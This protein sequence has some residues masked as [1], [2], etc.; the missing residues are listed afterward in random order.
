MQLTH[1][2]IR[3]TIERLLNGENYRPE[4]LSLIDAEF[5][6]FVIA[7]FR[8]IVEAKLRQQAVTADWYRHEFLEDS[9]MDTEAIAIHAGLNMKTIRNVYGTGSRRVVLEASQEHF[10][11]LYALINDLTQQNEIDVQ[12]TLKFN[13]VSVELTLSESL[14]V[15]NTLAVKR[16]QLRGSLWSAVG[17]QV[18]KPLMVALC[19]LFQVP[20]SHYAF[21]TSTRKRREVDF[22]LI[23]STGQ[24]YLCEVKLMGK[25]NPESADATFARGTHVFIADTL[26]DSSKEQLA[27]AGVFWIELKAVN[28]WQRFGEAL[29]ILEIPHTPF[30]G[31]LAAKLPVILDRLFPSAS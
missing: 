15:I 30:R 9:D 8:R 22:C 28:S 1:L 20:A 26:S 16:A 25:G 31:D 18:E 2:V 14:I 21:K 12:L 29:S 24:E 17:K 10:A 13:S 27:E 23:G 4:I 6:D 19:E 3:R 11:Q 5:L 7:F